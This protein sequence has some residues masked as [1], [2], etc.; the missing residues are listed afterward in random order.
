MADDKIYLTNIVELG[1][2]IVLVLLISGLIVYRGARDLFRPIEKMHQ[3]VSAIQLGLDRRIGCLDLTRGHELQILGKQFDTMLD[4]LNQ[5]N[6][7]IKQAS[8]QLEDKV[9]RRTQS[10]GRRPRNL[11]ST[12]NC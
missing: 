2:G 3:V 11:N 7:V 10:L 4:Q 5:R 1:I 9:Q 8:L 6:E 12:L